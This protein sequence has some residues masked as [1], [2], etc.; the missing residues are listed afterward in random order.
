M[1]ILAI[2]NHH[3]IF[4]TR[5][6]LIFKVDCK[7]IFNQVNREMLFP[8]VYSCLNVVPPASTRQIVEIKCTQSRLGVSIIE[9]H[10]R[11]FVD[12]SR[13]IFDVKH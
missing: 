5:C 6:Y 10:L 13:L 9:R 4:C 7:C 11:D 3:N 12:K 8:L 1:L 2:T